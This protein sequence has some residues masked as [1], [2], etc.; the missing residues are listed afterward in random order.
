MISLKR[1]ASRGP[2]GSDLS[3]TT[4][5]AQVATHLIANTPSPFDRLSLVVVPPE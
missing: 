1:M 5:Y 2:T 4:R 3:S